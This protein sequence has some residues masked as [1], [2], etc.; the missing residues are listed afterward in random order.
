MPATVTL[1]KL[2]TGGEQPRLGVFTL[3]VSGLGTYPSGGF[4]IQ[5]AGGG[6]IK[7]LV[8]F[9]AA[10]NTAHSAITG[11]SRAIGIDSD[12]GYLRMFNIST[13]AELAGGTA[14]STLPPIPCL[15]V[16]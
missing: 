13:G 3:D 10:W 7:A 14:I 12:T 9:G 5:L 8:Q 16:Y 4:P 2:D 11:P 15:V 1:S 6:E